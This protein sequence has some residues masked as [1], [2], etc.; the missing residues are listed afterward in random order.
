MYFTIP[1]LQGACPFSL[2]SNPHYESVTPKSRAWINSFEVLSDRRQRHV[3]SAAPELLTSYAYP[4]ADEERF[5]AACDFMNIA[6][7]LDDYCD[8]EGKESTRTTLD[9]FMNALK[10]PTRDDGSVFARIARDYRARLNTFMPTARQHLIEAWGHFY[11]TMVNE[12]ENRENDTI[13]G[14]TAFMEFR[15]VNSSVGVMFALAEC[16]L[17]IDL[18]PGIFDH[19]TVSTLRRLAGNVIFITND[20]CSYNKEQA[21]GQGANNLITVIMKEKGVGLQG[22][23]DVSGQFFQNDVEAFLSHKAQLPHWG[24]EVD[25]SVSRYVTALESWIRGNVEWSLGCPMY[26]G[27]SIEEVRRTRQ[28]SL[29][30]GVVRQ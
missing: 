11:D 27:D 25:E 21:S 29:I 12:A 1:D 5:R 15:W 8:G 24:P 17:G 18:Q 20:I 9:S 23:F 19:P 22:A 3:S 14:L 2:S 13:L 30:E 6:F 7:V 10:D 16:L 4:Y 28:V 26:F